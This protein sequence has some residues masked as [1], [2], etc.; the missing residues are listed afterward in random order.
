MKQGE[1]DHP[2][3]S[4]YTSG[5]GHGNAPKDNPARPHEAHHAIRV[6]CLCFCLHFRLRGEPRFRGV[7]CAR[8]H[9]PPLRKTVLVGDTDVAIGI[10][11]AVGTL[12]AWDSAK[13]ARTRHSTSDP[14]VLAAN[15][16][17]CS[18]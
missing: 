4:V 15:R 12:I 10:E 6:A 18:S 16:T 14:P 2:R 8:M 3:S 13:Q 17:A 1:E 11:V 9:H 7:S 5:R